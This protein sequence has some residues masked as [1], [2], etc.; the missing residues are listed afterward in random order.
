MKIFI[1]FLKCYPNEGDF[2][3]SYKSESTKLSQDRVSPGV[4]LPLGHLSGLGGRRAP[5]P[6]Q[7]LGHPSASGSGQAGRK[8]T[9]LLSFSFK[10]FGPT[11][12]RFCNLFHSANHHPTRRVRF[13]YLVCGRFTHLHLVEGTLF[14]SFCSVSRCGT[15]R[16]Y[17]AAGT[18]R[19]LG[20][21]VP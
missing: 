8:F 4:T 11:F 17:T 9:F 18:Q 3:F 19:G 12:V 14:I 10:V 6:R 15:L 20:V 21:A 5:H 16:A 13:T 7:R 2:H 1:S